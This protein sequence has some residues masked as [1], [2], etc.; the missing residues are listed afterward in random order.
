M[1]FLPDGK[2]LFLLD[3]F[4]TFFLVKIEKWDPISIQLH[5]VN[6]QNKISFLIYPARSFILI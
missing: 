2:Y 6:L 4:G 1:R 3:N 5:Q